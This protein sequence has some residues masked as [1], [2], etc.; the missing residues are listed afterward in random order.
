MWE[1]NVSFLSLLGGGPPSRVWGQ[2]V[3]VESKTR[4]CN[5]ALSLLNVG[6]ELTDFD[7]DASRA[8]LSCRNF[9]GVALEKILRDY[10]WPQ[11]RARKPLSRIAELKGREYR[12]AYRLPID[13]K[14]FR[15]FIMP[16]RHL[17]Y[18]S[19]TYLGYEIGRDAG[20]LLVWTDEEKP[21]AEYTVDV[22]TSEWKG[23][24][25]LA[26][27]SLLASYIAPTVTGGD[28]FKLGERCFQ[29]Y[30]LDVSKAAAS[31]MNEQYRPPATRSGFEGAR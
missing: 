18:S 7:T 1:G 30:Q 6:I 11:F 15:G 16:T 25:T 2:G 29:R 3:G 19:E 13:C 17:A 22:P 14:Y 21:V 20:G 4:V 10:D 27:A 26:F 5:L 9:Y 31:A 8:G 12:Y 24:F 28:Q 23:D